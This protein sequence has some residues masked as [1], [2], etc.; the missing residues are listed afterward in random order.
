M[1]HPRG[2]QEIGHGDPILDCP[3]CL[4]L[5]KA[6]QGTRHLFCSKQCFQDNWK[7]HKVV[8][9]KKN[10][11]RGS[12]D[13]TASAA[14]AASTGSA[15]QARLSSSAPPAAAGPAEKPP[16]TSEG[17]TVGDVVT[18]KKADNDIPAGTKGK[19]VSFKESG[20]HKR[21][22]VRFTNG[23]AFNLKLVELTIVEKAFVPPAPKAVEKKPAAEAGSGAFSVGDVVAWVKADSDI[24]AGTTGEI[25]NFRE[26]GGHK[27][28]GVRWNNGFSG[29]MKLVELQVIGKAG[30]PA[31][32]QK[33]P[34]D[35]TA[36]VAFD[37]TV[38]L[39]LLPK[40]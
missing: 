28:A 13:S 32:S 2:L 22:G 19:V 8:H 9:P 27:R 26:S 1:S 18:W 5:A 4:E 35:S 20:G 38:E 6:G 17:F 40:A 25:I 23:A 33:K 15:E 30:A 24:P 7:T 39:A 14:S 31:A 36:D 21:A 34:R 3:T 37:F 16:A 29:N 11:R 10:K 12:Q